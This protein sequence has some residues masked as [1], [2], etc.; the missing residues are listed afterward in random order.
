M[1]EVRLEYIAIED[2]EEEKE[3]L[4]VDLNEFEKEQKSRAAR[5]KKIMFRDG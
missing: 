3:D 1:K 2:D 4:K 5:L